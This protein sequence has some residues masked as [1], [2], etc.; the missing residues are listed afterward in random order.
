[1]RINWC[2]SL[3]VIQQI[4]GYESGIFVIYLVA[5]WNKFRIVKLDVIGP[6]KVTLGCES[7]KKDVRNL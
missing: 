2:D 3:E 7:R 4:Y 6:M 1:M 5:F